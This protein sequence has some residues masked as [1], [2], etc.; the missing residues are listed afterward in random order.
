MPGSKNTVRGSYLP[1]EYPV[2]KQVDAA[3]LCVVVAVVLSVAADVL[4]VLNL[5]R[6]SSLKAGSTRQRKGGEGRSNVRN[7]V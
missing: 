4:H 3:E 1:P 2:V 7:S 5:A 6:S